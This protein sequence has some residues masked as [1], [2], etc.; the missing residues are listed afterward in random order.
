[1]SEVRHSRGETGLTRHVVV[2]GVSGSGKSTVAAGLAQLLGWRLGEAD[3]FHPQ[4]NKDKMAAG[5]PLD[6][7]DRRP[8]LEGLATWMADRSQAGHSTV[9]ACSALKRRYRDILRSGPPELGCI[10]LHGPV[11]TI[12]E[13]MAGREGHFMPTSLL[14]S[15]LD[16]L[17]PLEGDELGVELDVRQT[18]ELLIAAAQDWVEANL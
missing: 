17:E 7:D 4:S 11:E 10:H 5:V 2:M 9:I 8:W 15:Q 3:H 13:R 6:D 12:A 16:I 1:M 18:P 14:Q